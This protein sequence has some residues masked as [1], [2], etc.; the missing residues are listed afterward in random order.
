MVQA[1]VGNFYTRVCLCAEVDGKHSQHMLKGRG[2]DYNLHRDIA[3]ASIANIH[4]LEEES[5]NGDERFR[6]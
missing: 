4:T 2:G 5:G 1:A 6:L 3:A